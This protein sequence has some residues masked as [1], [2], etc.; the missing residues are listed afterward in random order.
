MLIA[1]ENDHLGIVLKLL[2]VGADPNSRDSM[3]L[4]ALL[5]SCRTLDN[6]A[7]AKALIENGADIHWLDGAGSSCLGMAAQGGN[8]DLV[9]F[10][11]E[12]GCSQTVGVAP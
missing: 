2:S 11:L 10:L 6:F 12:L 1:A 9:K 7:C 3:G 8:L 5:C 4:T